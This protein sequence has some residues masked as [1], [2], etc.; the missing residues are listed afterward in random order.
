[1]AGCPASGF[2]TKE[3]FFM[4]HRMDC[5]PTGRRGFT[6]VELLVVIAIIAILLGLLLPA[7]Q[8][9]R[10]AAARIKCANNLR[11]LALAC[12]NHESA[13]GHLPSAGGPGIYQGPGG[14]QSGWAWQALPF[15]DGGE[16]VRRLDWPGQARAGLPGGLGQCPSKPNPRVYPQWEKGWPALM[17]D[18]CGCDLV[19]DDGALRWGPT[20]RRPEEIPDGLSNTLLLAEKRLNLAQARV[21][22]NYDD[23]F[24]PFGGCDWDVLRTCRVPPAPD[25]TGRVGGAKWPKG[26]SPDTG[27]SAFGSSHPGGLNA[28]LCDGSVRFLAYTIRPAVFAALGTADGGE[29][30]SQE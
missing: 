15:L 30:V 9:V 19:A 6:L 14:A 13:L 2:T 12:L 1:M 25:Y 27:G 29:V 28:A 23:D 7:V 5:Q 10:D 3:S 18:Y 17:C 21:G 8:K 4:R 22:R 24:G 26:Y 20:G 11:Q 16:I